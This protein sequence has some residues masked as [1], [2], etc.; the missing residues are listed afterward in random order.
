VMAAFAVGS[1]VLAAPEAL[2]NRGHAAR[3]TPRMQAVNEAESAVGSAD[4]RS[5][6]P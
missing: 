2:R 3:V 4:S 1:A 6:E 5:P